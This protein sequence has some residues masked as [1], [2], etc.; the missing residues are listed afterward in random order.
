M[1]DALTLL[2]V[3]AAY[4]VIQSVFGVGLLVFGTPTLLL[5]GFSFEEVLAYL[6]P[7]S[8]VISAVQ[9]HEGGLSL[10]PI[11]RKFL[12]Y[13]APAVL[14]G[15]VLVLVVLNHKLNIR[16]LVGAML[17]LTAAVR[18]LPPLREQM[19]RMIR[20]RLS[21]FLGGLGIVHGLSNLGGGVLTVIVSSLYR[22]KDDMRKHIAFGYGV[23]GA[24]QLA[25]LFATRAVTWD[26]RLQLL[27]PPLAGLMYYVLGQRVFE[28]TRQGV[29][30]VSLTALI[31]AFGILLLVS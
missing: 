19:R 23:M 20:N 1:H 28:A 3:V 14:V 27:L 10:E 25:T 24:I 13:T 26:W 7:C 2:A 29:Y 15:T 5:A 31:A 18:L 30:E 6:L 16:S 11:R 21:L 12:V 8:I 17:I 22:E 9:V 4:S